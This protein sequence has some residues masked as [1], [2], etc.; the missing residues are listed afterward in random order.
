MPRF[1][2]ST[3]AILAIAILIFCGCR[4]ENQDANNSNKSAESSP[5]SMSSA[6]TKPEI[7]STRKV[8]TSVETHA[9]VEAAESIT[10]PRDAASDTTGVAANQGA[11]PETQPSQAIQATTDAPDSPS[12]REQETR[13]PSHPTTVV[14]A[15]T[16]LDLSKFP[17][18]DG[19]DT[20]FV[21]QSNMHYNTQD[22]LDTA[23]VTVTD[24]ILKRGFVEQDSIT[25]RMATITVNVDD[26]PMTI[27]LANSLG[28]NLTHVTMY[29]HQGIDVSDVPLLP[30]S[31]PID[32]RVDQVYYQTKIGVR[33]GHYN[34]RAEI[35]KKKIPIA[36]MRIGNGNAKKFFKDGLNVVIAVEEVDNMEFE[37]P[38]NGNS[39][40]TSVAIF[41]RGY[42]DVMK[43]PRPDDF[44]QNRQAYNSI[45]GSAKF[46]ANS[47]PAEAVKRATAELQNAGWKKVDPIRESVGDSQSQLINDGMLVQVEAAE[48]DDRSHVNYNMSL[49]PYDIPRNIETR[50]IRVDSAAPHMFFAST[51]DLGSLREFYEQHMAMLGWK[52]D[53]SKQLIRTDKFAQLYHGSHFQPV[54]LEIKNR[55]PQTTWVELR[56]VDE[57]TI[58][59]IFRELEPEAE[60]AM[61]TEAED[62]NDGIEEVESALND[63]NIP[64]SADQ[65]E[66]LA[67]KQMEEALK[68]VPADQ[69]AEIKKMMEQQLGAMFDDE[70][71]AT[72]ETGE[73]EET[74]VTTDESSGDADSQESEQTVPEDK[75]AAEEFPIPDGAKNV[76]TDFEMIT[77][78]ATEVE[79][80]ARFITDKLAAL[81]WKTRGE[82]II[83]SDLG[84]LRFQKGVGTIN[85]SL[86]VDDRRDPPVHVVAHGDGIWFPGSDEFEEGLEYEGEME[87]SEF[88]D[89]GAFDEFDVKEFEGVSLPEGVDSPLKMRSQFRS[90]LVT[91]VEG[92]LK[93]IHEFFRDAASKTDWKLSSE[94]LNSGDSVINLSNDRGELI[95]ELKKFEGEIEIHLAFRDPELARKDGFVPPAGKARLFLANASNAETTITIN[96]KAYKLAPEQGAENPKDA[97]RVDVAPGEYKYSIKGADRKE[98]S[99]KIKAVAGGSWGIIVFPEQG[100]MAERMY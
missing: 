74:T 70:A 22:D 15:A 61:A 49:L 64:D 72:P 81:D 57:Q 4:Q 24:E 58:L 85:V 14:H 83:E 31:G 78:G 94:N 51:E 32:R 60:I 75:I 29:H 63:I 86:T 30:A 45:F 55:G 92:E 40:S 12:T 95:V 99:E 5:A 90:E 62:S 97:L 84:M 39:Q 3:V 7:V 59:K 21:L 9:D 18:P 10:Q 11:S 56:P 71:A 41:N 80:N 6:K 19:A 20:S 34:L 98:Q 93:A 76:T 1:N 35:E 88:G 37:Y 69:A 38:E 89:D 36:R 47:S 27:F 17:K 26:R 53:R 13:K 91:S 2:S 44:E 54:A 16:T 46:F 25:T 42:G 100:H 65:I 23:L 33:E 52:P 8:A 82:Q 67:R 96:G 48:F 77:F 50:M 43:L 79:K 66:A 87:G 68:N 28:G 73:M